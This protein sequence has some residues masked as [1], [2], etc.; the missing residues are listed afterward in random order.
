MSGPSHI[1]SGDGCARACTHACCTPAARLLHAFLSRLP[2]T[3]SCHT[4]HAA[5]QYTFE[6]A[7]RCCRKGATRNAI[8]AAASVL[9][10]LPA[11]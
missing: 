4:F 5:P 11:S 2:L 1:A 8:A 3:P 10:A 7:L 9:G 6:E